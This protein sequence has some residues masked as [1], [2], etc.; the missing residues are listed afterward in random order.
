MIHLAGAVAEGSFAFAT[1][2]RERARAVGDDLFRLT[3]QSY[4]ERHFIELTRALLTEHR[5]AVD[6]V[7]RGL[8]ENRFVAGPQL[9]R[10]VD[11]AL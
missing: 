10:W 1:T 5:A 4:D 9:L 8:V 11:Y 3:G 2:D 6:L 7:A